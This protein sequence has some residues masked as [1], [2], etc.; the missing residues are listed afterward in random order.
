MVYVS[1][2]V[3]YSF[4]VKEKDCYQSAV[5]NQQICLTNIFVNELIER[6]LGKTLKEILAA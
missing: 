3:C 5:F 4:C 2:D 1:L 6:E